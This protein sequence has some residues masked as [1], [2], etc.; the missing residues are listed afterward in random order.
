MAAALR[1][2][3]RDLLPHG[4]E[5]LGGEVSAAEAAALRCGAAEVG[6]QADGAARCLL[7]EFMDPSGRDEKDSAGPGGV[8]LPPDALLA[9]AAQVEQQLAVGVAVRRVAFEGLEVAVDPQGAHRP[10]PAAQPEAAQDN[11]RHGGGRSFR[12]QHNK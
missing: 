9:A 7:P 12:H 8:A 1:G 5:G 6:H 2:Q 11:G 4:G 3:S 10:V